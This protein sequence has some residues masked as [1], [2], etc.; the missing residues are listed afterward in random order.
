MRAAGFSAGA[1]EA[2]LMKRREE[3]KRARNALIEETARLDAS[4]PA[5]SG[6]PGERRLISVNREIQSPKA[7]KDVRA[8]LPDVET[9]DIPTDLLENP[10]VIRLAQQLKNS[11]NLRNE[12][13]V[14]CAKLEND[15]SA[16]LYKVEDLKD[17]LE[18]Q[19]ELCAETKITLKAK[20]R[21]IEKLKMSLS[22]ASKDVE[23]LKN[24][25]EQ[26]E[27]LLKEKAGIVITQ[28]GDIME[29][30]LDSADS[31]TKDDGSQSKY[32]IIKVEDIENENNA[33]KE[34]INNLKEDIHTRNKYDASRSNSIDD[35]DLVDKRRELEKAVSMYKTR[36]TIEEQDKI[37]LQGQISVL[38]SQVKRY[39][40]QVENLSATEDEAQLEKRRIQ[41]EM[42]SV[43]DEL[44][45]SKDDYSILVKKMEKM[46]K[47]NQ[48]R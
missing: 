8:L 39:K 36:L 45:T 23:L 9:V 25:V 26:R 18:D 1:G 28:L 20:C 38:E 46:Q 11:E 12:V 14:N 37:K 10:T 32:S 22:Q 13:L 43:Q 42:R 48:H 24:Q 16:L 6:V 27:A 3:R 15:R 5:S 2:K 44:Q 21:D 19:T 40:G 35:Q 7:P 34:E 41:R 4:N 30:P 17:Q 47:L 31:N 29:V 33:L